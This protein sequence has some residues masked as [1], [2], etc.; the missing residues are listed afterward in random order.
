MKLRLLAVVLMLG[1]VAG[2][3]AITIE[4]LVADPEMWPAEVAT[5]G[6]IRATVLK[7]GKPAGAMLV[8][9]GKKIAVLEI[10]ATGITGKTG[11]TTV[12]VPLEKTNLWTEVAR[13]HPDES[14]G[15]PSAPAPAASPAAALAPAAAGTAATPAVNTPVAETK[16]VLKPASGKVLTAPSVMQR[17]LAGKIMRMEN[18]SLKSVDAATLG[19]IKLFGLYYSA[20]WCGPCRRFTPGFVEAYKEIKQRHPE[21]EVVFMSSD[22]SA[23][24]MSQYMKDDGM[25]WLALK[26]DEARRDSELRRYGGPGIPCLV[27]VDPAGRVLSDSFEGD[28]YLGP[29]KVLADAQRLLAAAR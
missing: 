2:L 10:T 25:P 5:L 12:L 18:G 1:F 29:G 3:P 28:N 17:R 9:A 7:D 27:L 8:G 13:L 6:S 20:S 14:G 26:Y 11:A 22:H 24:D 16:P 23:G 19:G 21:F 15:V 4:E